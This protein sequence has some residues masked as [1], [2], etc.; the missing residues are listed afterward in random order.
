MMKDTMTVTS[1]RGAENWLALLALLQTEV[2]QLLQEIP[3]DEMK[4]V[5]GG[6][7]EAIAT[8]AAEI[9]AVLRVRGILSVE[10][11]LADGRSTD[12]LLVLLRVVPEVDSSIKAH[13]S[14]RTVKFFAPL[15]QGLQLS[16]PPQPDVPEI[17]VPYISEVWPP[18][19]PR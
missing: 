4:S 15:V 9:I 18:E 1:D 14:G 6:F 13:S 3:R 8:R 11:S 7:G 12:S 10:Y 5:G 17:E 16:M 2:S 19:Y